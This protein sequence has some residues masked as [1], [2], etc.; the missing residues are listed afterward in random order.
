MKLSLLAALSMRQ[1]VTVVDASAKAI[2]DGMRAYLTRKL[3]A[4]I[5]TPGTAQ[6][7][8]AGRLVD[9]LVAAAP[10]ADRWLENKALTF[11]VRYSTSSGSVVTPGTCCGEE[12][13]THI[14]VECATSSRYRTGAGTRLPAPHQ[15]RWCASSASCSWATAT[16][17]SRPV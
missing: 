8:H 7:A 13:V 2:P 4:A 11:S 1:T 5:S 16:V 12:V 17:M 15:R 3:T 9:A 14:A 10:K 6:L